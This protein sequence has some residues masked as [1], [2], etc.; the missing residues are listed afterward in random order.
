MRIK[1]TLVFL[2]LAVT[3]IFAQ[4]PGD[5]PEFYEK[6]LNKDVL[7]A[8]LAVVGGVKLLRNVIN[9]KGFLA[10][11]V[12]IGASLIY[13]L[14]QFGFGAN[15]VTYGLVVGGLSA[16]AFYL[17]KNFGTIT[18]AFGLSNQEGKNMVYDRAVGFLKI[19]S[20]PQNLVIGLLRIIR[21]LLLRR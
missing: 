12:T 7:A 14:I 3:V 1:F 15:T 19:F 11:V 18:G 10:V 8:V 21:Y 5:I 17:T 2:L 13:G 4:T 16:L 20:D 9:V 6:V